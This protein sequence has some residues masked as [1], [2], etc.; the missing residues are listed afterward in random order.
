MDEKIKKISKI[1]LVV[2][3]CT[4]LILNVWFSYQINNIFTAYQ[5][6]QFNTKILAFTDMFVKDVLMANKEVD[7]ETRLAL[8]TAVRSLGDQDIFD[9]WQRFTKA[10]TK[11]DASSQVK[12][13]LNLLIGKMKS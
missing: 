1:L 4:S 6:V 13:F 8:E 10:T 11:E 3:F 9:Q 12:I 5:S 7:L 2:I